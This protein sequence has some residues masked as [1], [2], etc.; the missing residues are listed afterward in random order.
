MD[1]TAPTY[2]ELLD[3]TRRQARPIDQWR[4]EVERLKAELEQSRRAGKRQAAP[5]SKGPPKAHPKRPG[6]KAGHPPS[7]RPLPP[8]ELVDRTI[9]VPLPP[10]CPEC[11]AALAEAPVT[12][13][14]QYQID[15]PEPEPIVTR[16]RVPLA[17]GPACYRRVPGRHPEP[18]SDALG[19]AA[20]P[21]GPRRLG[22][23][24]D[25]KHRIGASYRQCSSVLLTLTGLVVAS[26]TLV[27]SGHRRRRLTLPS[28]DRRVE[29]ARHSAVQQ[30]DET[31]WK[32]GGRSAWLGVFADAHATLDRIR[33]SRGHE[34]VV[35]MLGDD[36]QGVW[37]SAC[38]LAY[39]PLNFP[40]SKGSSHLWK[41]C[42]EVEQSQNR[43]AV[44]FARRVA[45][46]IRRAM[47]RKRRRGTI[48]DHGSAVLRGKAHAE[49]DR[50]L[51]GTDTDPDNAR[52]ATLLR[53]HRDSLLRFLDHDFVDATNHLAEREGRPAV[54][55][56]K[57]SAGNRTEED[58]ETHAVLA[59]VLRTYRRQGRDILEAVVEWLRHGPGHILEFDHIAPPVPA[60]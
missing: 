25:L 42:S 5:V 13:H 40:K 4:A 26:A 46:L 7:P 38:F 39:D 17:R 48:G 41:R 34:V 10:E 22:F 54:L 2:G 12:V 18:T 44:R 28:D 37:V 57:L 50:L 45:T 47:T 60:Q 55:A 53:Q 9:A 11:H 43:G 16:F 14:D 49:L 6:R 24:A 15:R 32:R 19:A 21:Y 29:A 3:L 36:S 31:G 23:A 27:R 8:P 30:V 1:G 52:L 58:A 35:E 59:R 51:A 56:R 20:V 33:K